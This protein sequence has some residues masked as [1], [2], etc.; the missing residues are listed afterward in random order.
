MRLAEANKKAAVANYE[1][2]IQTAFAR[3][4]MPLRSAAP[5]TSKCRRKRS[6][7]NSAQVAARLSD[8]RYRVG[9][10]S[11][12]DALISQRA[13]YSAQQQLVITRLNRDLNLVELYRSLGGGLS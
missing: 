2:A 5:S 3:S 11:F 7:S 13:A 8:A 4:R 6:A 10:A 9:V 1:K 12:L